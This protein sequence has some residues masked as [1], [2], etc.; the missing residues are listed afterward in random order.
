MTRA[1]AVAA[2]VL[3]IFN[4]LGFLVPTIRGVWAHLGQMPVKNP[5]TIGGGNER[6]EID[7][8]NPPRYTQ[9]NPVLGHATKTCHCH[10]RE[11]EPGEKVLW[12]PRADVPGAVYIFCE[13]M[14][15]KVGGPA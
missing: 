9:Y 11:L 2:L 7:P 15:S 8:N 3:G 6:L 1:I 5:E 14:Y 13:E 12:W 10:G 4:T